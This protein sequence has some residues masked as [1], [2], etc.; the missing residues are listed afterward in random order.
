MLYSNVSNTKKPV[1]CIASNFI[2]PG[3]HFLTNN[4]MTKPF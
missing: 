4:V 3:L 1:I 2:K